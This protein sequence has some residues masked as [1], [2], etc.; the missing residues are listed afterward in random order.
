MATPCSDFAF[1]SPLHRLQ[2]IS[3]SIPVSYAE[4]LEA[5]MLTW[6]GGQHVANVLAIVGVKGTGRWEAQASLMGGR[7]GTA[8]LAVTIRPADILG[9]LSLPK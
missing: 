4:E 5:S 3:A 9:A 1:P 2:L 8:H 7:S 6:G